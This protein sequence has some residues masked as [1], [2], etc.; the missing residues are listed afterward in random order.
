MLSLQVSVDPEDYMMPAHIQEIAQF[1]SSATS[2]R[3]AG[4]TD[5]DEMI[6]KANS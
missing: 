5:L 3:P 6:G 2:A 4:E 1:F